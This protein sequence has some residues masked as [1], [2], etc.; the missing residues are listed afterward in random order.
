MI[1]VPNDPREHQSLLPQKLCHTC[2]GSTRTHG[3]G[4]RRAAL[5]LYVRGCGGKSEALAACPPARREL[6]CGAPCL[7]GL[8]SRYKRRRAGFSPPF[9]RGYVKGMKPKVSPSPAPRV[10]RAAQGAARGA[11]HG[12]LV[13]DGA[14]HAHLS[15]CQQEVPK[16]KAISVI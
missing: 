3:D 16:Y 12:R 2:Q 1:C 8:H 7:T 14:G 15:S 6:T 11:A 5:F 4:P 9:C 10:T 13:W